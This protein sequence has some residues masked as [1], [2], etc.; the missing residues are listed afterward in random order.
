MK[1]LYASHYTIIQLTFHTI[2]N[3]KLEESAIP[4]H[5]LNSI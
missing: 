4:Y 2:S 5:P 1:T 3:D